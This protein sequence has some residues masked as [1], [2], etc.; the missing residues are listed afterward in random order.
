MELINMSKMLDDD[1]DENKLFS[2]PSAP[3]ASPSTDAMVKVGNPLSKYFRLPGLL[4]TLP[5]KGAFFPKGGIEMD[6][7]VQVEV[8]PMRGADELLLSSP[9]ALMNNSAIVG[10]IQS[11]V[12]QIKMVEYVSAPDLDV[13]LLAIRVASTGE[14]MNVEVACE[15]CKEETKFELNIPTMLQSAQ[16][17]EPV[18]LVRISDE[19]VVQIN[20]LT[21][22]AQTKILT[23]AFKETRA[24]QAMEMDP[25]LTDEARQIQTGVIMRKLAD[26]NLYG[27]EQAVV[28][29]TVPDSEVT[30]RKHIAEFIQN[31]DRAKLKKIRDKVDELNA[32]GVDK[33][34]PAECSACGYEWRATVEFDPASFFESRSF[35]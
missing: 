28:K 34:F 5:T 11:C 10:L 27:V 19:M 16:S 14:N 9:D 23:A 26:L 8:L 17:I 3:V 18:N 12:P 21:L 29:V 33:T 4:V 13:L 20:P 24:I 32:K 25:E 1:F 6:E 22:A 15:K 35:D 31:T 30:D 7:N 2:A